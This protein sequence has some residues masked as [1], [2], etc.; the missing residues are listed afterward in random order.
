MT[1]STKNELN[2][3]LE[4]QTE[5]TLGRGRDPGAVV[6]APAHHPEDLLRRAD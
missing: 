2:R 5:D 3:L 1:K 6:D 4:F